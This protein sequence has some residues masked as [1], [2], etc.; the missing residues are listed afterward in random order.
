VAG[1]GARL[2]MGRRW[3]WA[4]VVGCGKCIY[5]Q[6]RQYKS[7]RSFTALG[8]DYSGGF[9]EYVK[10]RRRRWRREYYSGAG[11]DALERAALV[12]PLPAV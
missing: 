9:A 3:W 1:V 5:C 7:L 8:Y 11:R 10:I 2:E 12:K 4:T 6:R